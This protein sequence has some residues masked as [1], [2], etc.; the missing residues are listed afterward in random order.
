MPEHPRPHGDGHQSHAPQAEPQGSDSARPDPDQQSQLLPILSHRVFQKEQDRRNTLSV[1][2]Q[3]LPLRPSTLTA[4]LRGGFSTTADVMISCGKDVDASECQGDGSIDEGGD[5]GDNASEG[6]DRTV[7]SNFA[8]ELRCSDSQA[9]DFAHEID[10]ALVSVGL[11]G[12]TTSNG[13]DDD[14]ENAAGNRFRSDRDDNVVGPHSAVFPETAASILRGRSNSGDIARHIV[15]FSQPLDTL[16][17]GGFALA[18]LTEIAGLPGVGKTQLAMQLCVD[19]RLPRKYGGVGGSAVVIDAEGSWSGAAGGDRLWSIA[20]ALSDHVKSTALRRAGPNVDEV[21]RNSLLSECISPESVLEGIHI[22]RVHDEASQTCTLYNLPKFLLELEEKKT[23]VKLVVID[24]MAF[25]YRVASSSSSAGGNK[26]SSLST[27]HNLTRM[28]TFLMELATEFD[29]AVVA[30]NHLT[31][32]K[33]DNNNGGTKLVPALGES[34]AHSITSRLIVDYYDHFGSS[35][36]QASNMAQRKNEVRMCTLVK[37][38]HKP[39][40]NA[41]FEITDKGIRGPHPQ[42]F[43]SNAFKR[44]RLD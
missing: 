40:G 25:H 9:A 12:V 44:A 38:P 11:P 18:E 39:S 21:E 37:S 42:L 30:M 6:V 3:S 17:G 29:L 13:G 27:T 22:F 4:L 1:P 24:S 2:L 7:F 43:Q 20:H 26:N 32:R 35:D 28:A 36:G 31:T 10:G 34:W 41:L 23:P 19:T 5:R 15:S 14:G 8:N 33:D 16:L